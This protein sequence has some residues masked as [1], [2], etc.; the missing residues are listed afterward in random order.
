MKR[1]TPVPFV[2]MAMPVVN[3]LLQAAQLTD[4]D[5]ICDLGCGDGRVLVEAARRTDAHG[6]GLDHDPARL[7]E[8]R[9]RAFE[10]GVE[11]RIEF[12]EGDFEN[13]ETL[14]EIG[15][16]RA[17][18][19]VLYLLPDVTT[20]LWRRL[21]RLLS[22]G[23]RVFSYAFSIH[24]TAWPPELRIP[25]RSIGGLKDAS[26]LYMWTVPATGREKG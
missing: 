16:A 13:D 18:V 10:A 22:P 21:L 11:R 12:H 26:C 15:I 3:D 2:P 4:A 7:A 24:D 23:T 9:R 8:A 5:V 20:R 6:I 14:R 19:V 25:T 17:T 1:C